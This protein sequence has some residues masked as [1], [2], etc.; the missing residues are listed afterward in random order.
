MKHGA[1][2]FVGLM[3]LGS[4]PAFA[5]TVLAGRMGD[6]ALLMIDGQRHIVV[7]NHRR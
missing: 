3:G 2:L 4:L 1:A 7:F 5:Q 6:R